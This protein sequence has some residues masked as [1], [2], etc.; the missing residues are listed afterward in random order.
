MKFISLV[1]VLKVSLTAQGIIHFEMKLF[2]VGE[3]C[4]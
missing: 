2:L 4:A 1:V 3:T